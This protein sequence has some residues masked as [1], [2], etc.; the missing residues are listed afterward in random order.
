MNKSK[1][2]VISRIQSGLLDGFP[3]ERAKEANVYSP[4][5]V[6]K[7]SELANQRYELK[8]SNGQYTLGVTIKYDPD[9]DFDYCTVNYQMN[10][11]TALFQLQA[12][13][14]ILNKVFSLDT[15]Y[16]PKV[17]DKGILDANFEITYTLG[18]LVYVGYADDDNAPEDKK[19]MCWNQKTALP[20][21]FDVE[22]L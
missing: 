5:N 16:E 8:H 15:C 12:F 21:R 4:M 2:F 14:D 11:S 9:A 20:I 7:F 22:E 1:E 18:D 10:D 13:E 6:P 17:P 19:W 3:E